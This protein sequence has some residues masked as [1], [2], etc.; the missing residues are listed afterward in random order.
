MPMTSDDDSEL[1]RLGKYLGQVISDNF[2]L[3]EAID[4]LA[5]DAV[6]EVKTWAPEQWEQNEQTAAYQLYYCEY[7]RYQAIILSHAQQYLLGR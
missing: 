4:R 6:P 3:H 2:D 7:V 5:R 1:Q